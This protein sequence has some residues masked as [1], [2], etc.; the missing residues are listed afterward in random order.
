MDEKMR[1]MISNK[2]QIMSY[3]I[4]KAIKNRARIYADRAD[5]K[6]DF[7]L[8]KGEMIFR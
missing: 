1:L 6:T 5:L 4:R 3:F 7:N 8:S 2:M